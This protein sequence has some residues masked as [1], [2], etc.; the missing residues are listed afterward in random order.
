MLNLKDVV[1]V[2]SSPISNSILE[3]SV[4]DALL[5]ESKAF[6]NY[7]FLAQLLADGE[8]KVPSVLFASGD[9][10][11]YP[12]TTAYQGD[13]FS[14]SIFG[15]NGYLNSWQTAYRTD[16]S[17][18]ITYY[19]GSTLF[20]AFRIDPATGKCRLKSIETRNGNVAGQAGAVQYVLGY[21]ASS[22][23]NDES[24]YKHSFRSRHSSV[25][26]SE[27]AIDIFLW[28][29]TKDDKL[30]LGSRRVL[31]LY[32]TGSI[33]I[34]SGTEIFGAL[35]VAIDTADDRI[36]EKTE[37][38][39]VGKGVVYFN[40]NT[41]KLRYSENGGLFKN[42]GSGDGSG[43]FYLETCSLNKCVLVPTP[44][45]EGNKLGGTIKN[46][47]FVVRMYSHEKARIKKIYI[48]TKSGGSMQVA[49]YADELIPGGENYPFRYASEQLIAY[50][51]RYAGRNAGDAG[52]PYYMPTTINV[53][54]SGGWSFY[55]R[56]SST[57][58]SSRVEAIVCGNFAVSIS[59]NWDSTET[60]ED[61][62]A[63]LTPYFDTN[64]SAMDNLT[65]QPNNGMNFEMLTY[66]MAADT[67]SNSSARFTQ[68]SSPSDRVATGISNDRFSKLL[69]FV[70]YVKVVLE[71]VE[72][73]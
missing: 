39:Q 2:E 33:E 7:E 64:L 70:P 66:D 63:E 27:N 30:E 56:F 14:S 19:D 20:R 12:K 71:K 41:N 4:G 65:G 35:D 22:A 48:P 62:I 8:Y 36:S 6:S 9:G 49:V 11:F 73:E 21:N 34:V 29:L 1:G 61:I 55:D 50:N 24:Y 60:A 32:G 18:E 28:D 17:Y 54:S 42:F 10:G 25:S 57:P 51:P 69:N 43:G 53:N 52:N 23:V 26:N 72:E 38:S 68:N 45:T 37:L 58:D 13:F 5:K 40:K 16:E 59:I 67:I 44:K 31:S 15:R 46:Y 3:T 47:S